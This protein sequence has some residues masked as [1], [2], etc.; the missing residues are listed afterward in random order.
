MQ[1]GKII[2]EEGEYKDGFGVCFYSS[3]AIYMG[4][5]HDGL[6]PCVTKIEAWAFEN[7]KQLESAYMPW[8][9]SIATAA[10]GGCTKLKKITV[11]KG[12]VFNATALRDTSGVKIEYV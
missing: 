9:V 3:E 7:C 1:Y 6:P 12:C 5:W 4:H 2:F 10:F 11:K 8:V